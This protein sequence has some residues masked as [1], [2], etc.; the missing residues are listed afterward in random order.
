MEREIKRVSERAREGGRNCK[1][2]IVELMLTLL[3][4]V[5]GGRVRECEQKRRR[6]IIR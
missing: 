3:L 6:D 5:E 2:V 1:L 4:L